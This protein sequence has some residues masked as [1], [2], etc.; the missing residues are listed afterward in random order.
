MEYRENVIYRNSKLDMV[1]FSG[2]YTTVSGTTITF[3]YY[4]QDYLSNN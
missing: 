3:H 2:G 1:L 4:T